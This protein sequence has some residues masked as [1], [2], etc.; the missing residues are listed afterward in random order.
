M[1]RFDSILKKNQ[2]MH[3]CSDFFTFRYQKISFIMYLSDVPGGILSKHLKNL[4][5]KKVMSRH[6]LNKQRKIV[7]NKVQNHCNNKQLLPIS[8][9]F[10]QKRIGTKVVSC[11][12]AQQ[13]QQVLTMSTGTKGVLGI[14]RLICL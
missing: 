14:I 10:S 6:L 1:T 9:G 3:I 8:F 12:C 7:N 11:N 2:R 4:F 13:G 5:A